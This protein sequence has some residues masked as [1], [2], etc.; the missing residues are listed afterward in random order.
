MKGAPTLLALG[1][2]LMAGAVALGLAQDVQPGP[3]RTW[4]LPLDGANIVPVGGVEA[5]LER[6]GRGPVAIA[7]GKDGPERRLVALEAPVT[8]GLAGARSLLIRFRAMLPAGAAARP[9]VVLF[10]RQG[11]WFKVGNAGVP[12]GQ[13]ADDGL[14]LLSV[15]KAPFS[16]DSGDT[17][18]WRSVDR[19][20]VGLVV[21]G[22]VEG[23]FELLTA[24]FSS[25]PYR[26]SGPLGV[27]LQPAERWSVAQDQAVRSALTV[28]DEGPGGR[29]CMRLEFTFPGGRHMY[30]VPSLSLPAVDLD[31]Y[32][33]L[34]FG[35][36]AALPDGIG[37]VLVMLCEEGGAQY[38]CD[39]APAASSDWVSVE[40]PFD[41]LKLGAWTSDADGSLDLDQVRQIAVG[42]HG[43]ATGR[44]GAGS[45]SVAGIDFVP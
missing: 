1:S 14:S 8:G 32:R 38:Y 28:P 16:S 30:V 29:A 41:R 17:P 3:L 31:G 27:P 35:Y 40:L 12:V 25:E 15:R 23:T 19:V 2:A 37:G 7:F 24:E 21:D 26:P 10:Q 33:A 42:A 45:I 39:P 4:P 5:R 9:A 43:R 34:R 6:R 22:Q 20:W 18:D 11:A 44:G 13:W 36:R